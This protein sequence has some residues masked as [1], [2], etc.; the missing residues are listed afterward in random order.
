MRSISGRLRFVLP[1][2]SILVLLVGYGCADNSGGD[3][4]TT[5]KSSKSS[6][7]GSGGSD[8]S[9]N[10][11][12]TSG[13]GN[14]GAPSA[15]CPNATPNDGDP[16]TVP[17]QKCFWQNMSSGY[18]DEIQC[19]CSGGGWMCGDLGDAVVSSAGPGVGAGGA[20]GMGGAPGT[21]GT[22]G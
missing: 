4:S 15:G 10:P 14:G 20:T 1:A 19:V 21:G 3:S 6:T 22:G 9:S 18:V 7:T 11:S 8:G 5:S 13:G 16:C 17:M 2:V 12:A